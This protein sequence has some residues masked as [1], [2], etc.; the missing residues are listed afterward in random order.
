VLG[1]IISTTYPV[2]EAVELIL[3][4]NK[5]HLNVLGWSH[6]EMLYDRV[7]TGHRVKANKGVTRVDEGLHCLVKEVIFVFLHLL[8]VDF[9]ISVLTGDDAVSATW[10]LDTHQHFKV[11]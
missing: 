8:L 7:Q 4:T 2:D 1:G 11:F 6:T 5:K 10:L 9:W 3:D